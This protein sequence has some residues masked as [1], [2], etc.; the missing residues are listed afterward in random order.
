MLTSASAE[1]ATGY[2][3][4]WHWIGRCYVRRWCLGSVAVLD[5]ELVEDE[6]R[7]DGEAEADDAAGGVWT[8]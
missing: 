2:W 5:G 4:I 7:A 8:T 1:S 3:S 6:V